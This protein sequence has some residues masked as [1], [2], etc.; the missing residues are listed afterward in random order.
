MEVEAAFSRLTPLNTR[1][2]KDDDC[3][4]SF[5]E[6]GSYTLLPVLTL[7]GCEYDDVTFRTVRAQN[8]CGC[9]YQSIY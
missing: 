8:W 3:N 9:L 2:Y 5:F 7:L 1:E 6:F 4:G